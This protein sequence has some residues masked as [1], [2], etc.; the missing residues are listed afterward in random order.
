MAM[1][2]NHRMGIIFFLCIACCLTMPFLGARILTPAAA[3]YA[4]GQDFS[5]LWRLRVPRVLGAFLAGAGLS[6]CGLLFQTLFRNPLAS[7]YTLGISSGAALGASLYF[8]AGCTAGGFN[9]AGS[10]GSAIAGCIVSMALVLAVAGAKGNFSPTILLLAGVIVNFFFSSLVLCVQYL[11]NPHDAVR[12]M[13]WLMGSLAGLEPELVLP[14]SI[15]IWGGFA[16]IS[17]RSRELDLLLAGE[18][19]AASRGVNVKNVKLSVFFIGSAMVGA[20]V[21]ITG[22]IGFVGLIIPQICRLWLGSMHASLIPAAF[23]LGAS[24]LMLCDL[25]ARWFLYPAEMPVGIITSLAGAPFL[26]LMLFYRKKSSD[27][28]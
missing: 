20:I 2:N 15:V 6:L 9:Y 18:E 14:F 11:S 27:L 19:I 26:L 17:R 23:M 13:H 12:I 25:G 16:V 10:I 21:A 28:Y 3:I 1:S 5:I 4:D 7:P 8:T 22:P 24:F